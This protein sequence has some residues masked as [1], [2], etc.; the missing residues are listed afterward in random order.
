MPSTEF[1]PDGSLRPVN[2][3][4]DRSS[5][6]NRKRDRVIKEQTHCFICGDIVD[7]ELPAT[8]A[9]SPSVDHLIPVSKG[10]SDDL[11]NLFLAHLDCNKRRGNKHIDEVRFTPQSRVW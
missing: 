7:K 11:D 6:W 4:R 10:G 5:S 1:A 3:K 2:N 8:D 9:M